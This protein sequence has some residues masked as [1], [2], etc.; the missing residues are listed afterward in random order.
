MA[1]TTSS[2]TIIEGDLTSG[3]HRGARAA[4]SRREKII[5]QQSNAPKNQQ[6]RPILLKYRTDA[7]FRMKFVQ[8]EN[9]ANQDEYQSTKD[10]APPMVVV[11]H[12]TYRRRNRWRRWRR[13]LLCW[14]C[15][16]LAAG[17]HV[18]FGRGGVRDQFHRADDDQD[19]RPRA[20]KKSYCQWYCPMKKSTPTVMRIAGPIRPRVR[21]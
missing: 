16:P 11:G 12:L 18:A 14:R 21:Q 7:D 19:D 6:Q 10:G 3:N 20:V 5:D 8:K 13:R 9:G 1:D 17:I 15:L 2:R 4:H